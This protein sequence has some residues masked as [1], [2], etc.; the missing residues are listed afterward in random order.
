MWR[1]ARESQGF[2]MITHGPSGHT[3][4]QSHI[5]LGEPLRSEETQLDIMGGRGWHGTRPSQTCRGSLGLLTEESS[6]SSAVRKGSAKETA[7]KRLDSAPPKAVHVLSDAPSGAWPARAQDFLS[8]SGYHRR[9]E[10]GNKYSA[11]LF[12]GE[13]QACVPD[14]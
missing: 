13:G 14:S 12:P 4:D 5:A 10:K 1:M 8:F 3:E 2:E 9:F 6:P 11:R 7:R